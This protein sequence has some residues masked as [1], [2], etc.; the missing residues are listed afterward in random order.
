M[1]TFLKRRQYFLGMQYV[2]DRT[3]LTNLTI[4]HILLSWYQRICHRRKW[5]KICSN[6]TAV[7]AAAISSSL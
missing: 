5:D 6:P 3:S 2:Q 4:L 1:A 7:N